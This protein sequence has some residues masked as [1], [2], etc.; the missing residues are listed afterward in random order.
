MDASKEVWLGSD[1]R[2]LASMP[3]S[4]L[5]RR[6]SEET[7]ETALTIR[8]NHDILPGIGVGRGRGNMRC[9]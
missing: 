1:E 6:P 8:V 2:F 4:I 5:L 7:S 9:D 3:W